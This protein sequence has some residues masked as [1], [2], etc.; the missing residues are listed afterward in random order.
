L[1]TLLETLARGL[2]S[3]P[4]RVRV[5]EHEEDGVVYLDLEVAGSDRGRVIGRGGRTIDALRTLLRAVGDRVGT[6]CEVEVAE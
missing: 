4:S 3:E 6:P 2:V 5:H 1:K